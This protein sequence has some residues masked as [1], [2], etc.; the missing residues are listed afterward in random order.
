MTLSQGWE[1][2]IQEGAAVWNE[3]WDK[4]E[5]E[6]LLHSLFFVESFWVSIN[7]VIFCCEANVFLEKV[8]IDTC[9]LRGN[10]NSTF[11]ICERPHN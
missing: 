8:L 5:D 10:A 3:E 2:G 4:F 11:R 7:N 6:G 9:H 1:P